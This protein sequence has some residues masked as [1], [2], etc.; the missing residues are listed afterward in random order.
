MKHRVLALGL[1]LT[2]LTCTPSFS[3]DCKD[4]PA[5]RPGAQTESG[6]ISKLQNQDT[7]FSILIEAFR[8]I[9]G[10]II[11][12][13]YEACITTANARCD[14]KTHRIVVKLAEQE[15]ELRVE[16]LDYQIVNLDLAYEHTRRDDAHAV[17]VDVPVHI[18]AVH[19]AKSLMDDVFIAP[20]APDKDGKVETTTVPARDYLLGRTPDPVD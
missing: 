11:Q 20:T 16:K 7:A 3:A 15:R 6:P 9:Q 14:L 17:A 13:D 8:Q 5:L 12:N 19:A 4:E 1:T 18:D 2:M 10:R